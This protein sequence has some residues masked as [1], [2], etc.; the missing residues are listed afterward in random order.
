MDV[1]KLTPEQI[2]ALQAAFGTPT[3]AASQPKTG[4]P[5]NTASWKTTLSGAVA[6]VAGFIQFAHQPPMNIAMPPLLVAAAQYLMLAGIGAGFAF[7]KDFNVTG[8][9][10]AQPGIAVAD[11]EVVNRIAAKSEV[12]AL[13]QGLG[14]AAPVAPAAPATNT[15]TTTANTR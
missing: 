4:I 8:G 11:P 10:I 12:A 13:L 15:V 6:L 7:S 14:A 2:A 3:P 9:T 5:F 1:T